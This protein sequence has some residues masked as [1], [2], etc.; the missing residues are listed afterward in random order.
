MSC[1]SLSEAQGIAMTLDGFLGIF[2]TLCDARRRVFLVW[3]AWRRV[4]GG[5]ENIVH[6]ED[7]FFL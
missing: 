2:V 3:L 5:D 4:L 1:Q 6:I 7:L